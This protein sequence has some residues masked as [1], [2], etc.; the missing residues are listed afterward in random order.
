MKRNNRLIKLHGKKKSRP[1]EEATKMQVLEENH[2]AEVHN[3]YKLLLTE[4][5]NLY[6]DQ[7]KLTRA[8]KIVSAMPNLTRITLSVSIV[9]AII[10]F[11]TQSLGIALCA[12][13]LNDYHNR[14]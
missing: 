1:A 14:S 7:S 6:E 8:K 9:M 3:I 10:T 2:R 13:T 11:F 12:C 4:T 5:S